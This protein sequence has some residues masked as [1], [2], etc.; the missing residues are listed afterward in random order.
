MRHLLF[1]AVQ[2]NYPIVRHAPAGIQLWDQW[3]IE[4]T[5]DAAVGSDAVMRRTGA[6]R[7]RAGP[8]L[9]ARRRAVDN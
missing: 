3:V 5:A 8:Q 6:G 7:R 1:H 4:G 9:E 2:F